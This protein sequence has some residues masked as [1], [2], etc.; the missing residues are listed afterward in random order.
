MTVI[1][2]PESQAAKVLVVGRINAHYG[3]KGWLK[4]Y[5]YTDPIENLLSYEQYFVRPE[6]KMGR[7][8]P[9][10]PLAIAEGKVHGKGLVIRLPECDTREASAEYIMYQIGVAADVMPA[11]E[12]GDYYWHQLVKLQVVT[13]EQYG[14][15]L[16]GKVSHFIETG[17]NDV[18]VVQSC[19]GS[20]DKTERLI[21]YVPDQFVLEIDLEA[22][23]LVV[24][25]DPEF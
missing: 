5:S 14:S 23:T 11:L 15:V 4:V 6:P 10:L 17:S 20:V 2:Q 16:L 8:K 7:V 24:D 1:T 12:A 9:W 3:V 13:S 21:P 25:W 19:Q 22:Q 18:M